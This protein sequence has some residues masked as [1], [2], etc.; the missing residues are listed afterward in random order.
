LSFF[1]SLRCCTTVQESI[2]LVSFTLHSSPS[3][4]PTLLVLE[5]TSF[6]SC[7]SCPVHLSRLLR[8]PTLLRRPL[9][10]ISR[11]PSKY[12]FRTLRALIYRGSFKSNK[13]RLRIFSYAC[14]PHPHI[15]NCFLG[16]SDG[17]T[18]LHYYFPSDA[19]AITPYALMHSLSPRTRIPP[20]LDL[21]GNFRR[22]SS[23]DDHSA[24]HPHQHSNK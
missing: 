8:R 23:L 12:G 18:L 5:Y 22:T 19:Y 11:A 9:I 24:R 14:A 13:N 7:P 3:D 17:F 1:W 2:H 16:C 10:D 6:P 15:M 20:P 4:R 21:S